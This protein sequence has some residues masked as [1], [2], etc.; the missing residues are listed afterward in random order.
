MPVSARAF[1]STSNFG[2]GFDAFG[3]SITV[4]FDVVTVRAAESG[5]TLTVVGV[6]AGDVPTD[7]GR[8]T[9]G[10]ALSALL[11]RHAPQRGLSARIH[12]GIRHGSGMG[13][14]AASAAAAV[15]AANAELGL[16]LS[17]LEMVEL[18]AEGERASAGSAHADN[19][20]PALLGGFT[21]VDKGPPLRVTRFDAP[22]SL[23][24][25]MA[26]PNIH[27]AT[28]VARQRMPREVSLETYAR[29]AARSGLIVAA[30][31]KGDSTALGHAIEDSFTDA[32]RGPLIPA[33]DEVRAA[34]K[35]AGAA[36]VTISGAGPTV[37]AVVGPDGH[38]DD[39]A[40]AMCG[41][42]GDAGLE[43]E[44]RIARPAPGAALVEGA[45]S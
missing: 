4:G 28:S 7:P 38:G 41:A 40:R 43:C 31:L 19:V 24:L 27:V 15:F 30:I 8:N 16:N 9:A 14:S 21:I 11:A 26:T 35:A 2:W 33:F 45:A 5:V 34:A 36:G 42:F 32:A 10:I 44:A 25:V 1:T 23:R 3:M 18:A 29:G 37:M 20:A 22:V 17:P 13:S 39:I 6:G 12:K